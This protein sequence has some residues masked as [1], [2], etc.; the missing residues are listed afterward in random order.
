MIKVETVL[1]SSNGSVLAQRLAPKPAGAK[2]VVTT[3]KTVKKPA[4]KR[5]PS[6]KQDKRPAKSAEDLDAEMEEYTQIKTE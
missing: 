4:K 3:K 1:E 5:A 6:A 2:T